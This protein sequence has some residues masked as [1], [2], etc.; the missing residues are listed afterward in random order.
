MQMSS[1]NQPLLS[2]PS[3]GFAK[4]RGIGA[5]PPLAAASVLNT[6]NCFIKLNVRIATANGWLQRLV[7]CS[8]WQS[9]LAL[10]LRSL[11]AARRARAAR[12]HALPNR[13]GND[14]NDGGDCRLNSCGN[15]ALQR[16]GNFAAH[17]AVLLRTPTERRYLCVSANRVRVFRAFFDTPAFLRKLP[18][19]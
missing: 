3:D 9:S 13:T 5:E 7:R 6:K 11:L 14:G 18:K 10:L 15:E 12:C 8:V 16:N 17:V 1:C 19:V 2:S 4:E